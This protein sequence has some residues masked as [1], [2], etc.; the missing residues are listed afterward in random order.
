MFG[1]GGAKSFRLGSWISP[2]VS[3]L[4][5]L[6]FLLAALPT[7]GNLPGVVGPRP[8]PAATLG[9]IDPAVQSNCPSPSPTPEETPG[10]EAPSSQDP[11]SSGGSGEGSDH[12]GGTEPPPGGSGDA[13]SGEGSTGEARG[14]SNKTEEDDLAGEPDRG[15]HSGKGDSSPHGSASFYRPSGSYSTDA[16]VAA[17]LRLRSLG[18]SQKRATSAL[19]PPFIIA[20]P[21]AWTNTWGAPRFGPGPL[22]RTHQGQDVFCSYGA[23]VLATED[24]VVDFG[25]GGLGGRVARVHTDDGAYWYY[26]HLSEFS[27][28]LAPGSEVATGDVLG[29]CGNTGN[30]TKTA[31][32]V[33]FGWYQATGR[34]R[35]PMGALVR[36]LHR[37]E[38]KAARIMDK[39]MGTRARE[40]N[41]LTTGYMFGDAFMPDISEAPEMVELDK[42]RTAVWLDGLTLMDFYVDSLLPQPPDEPQ[43]TVDLGHLDDPMHEDDVL[44]DVVW[45]TEVVPGPSS[46]TR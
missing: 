16:L 42:I 22:V 39:E 8:V 6:W 9:C 41:L 31:P 7:P 36:W 25:E 32:H 26:A 45:Q 29:Y 46:S 14:G 13:D 30:A 17:T 10:E 44:E 35:D 40:M 21:A 4:V 24:G 2:G 3:G 27:A 43:R 15:R 33:H 38:A 23:P 12:G 1:R 28:A 37:A 34:A 18:W 5:L 20:G 19:Y 11:P